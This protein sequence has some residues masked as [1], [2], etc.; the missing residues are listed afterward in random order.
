MAKNYYLIYYLNVFKST[1]IPIKKR[2]D[3]TNKIIL[4]IGI[5][6]D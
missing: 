4:L 6:Y 1:L 5:Y 3:Y 2:D